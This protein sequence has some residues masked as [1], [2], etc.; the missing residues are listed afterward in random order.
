MTCPYPFPLLP[1]THAQPSANPLVERRAV[2]FRRSQSEVS[3][4][5]HHVLVQF[6]NSLLP[7]DGPVLQVGDGSCLP[8]GDAGI[9]AQSSFSIAS[10][11]LPVS[12]HPLP[13]CLYSPGTLR[14]ASHK[15][16]SRQTCS[17]GY[18]PLGLPYCRLLTSPFGPIE[19][20]FTVP[21]RSRAG[22]GLPPFS[23]SSFI[24]CR[25]LYAGGFFAA[26]PSSEQ[27]PWPLSM[28]ARLGFLFSLLRGLFDDAAG[29]T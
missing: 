11:C 8:S 17:F 7:G 29:F 12:A 10:R 4:P 6:P 21:G 5:A 18:E 13:P 20:L 24:P 27:L 16:F 19:R 3:N 26:A 9:R 23:A 15:T 28:Y 2:R 1:Q 25:S 14:L 22:E